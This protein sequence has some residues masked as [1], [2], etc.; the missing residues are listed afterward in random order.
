MYLNA[1][2]FL[3]SYI[4]VTY[5]ELGSQDAATILAMQSLAFLIFSPIIGDSMAV[6]GRKNTLI[7]SMVM[8]VVSTLI[9][10]VAS[11]STSASVFYWGSIVAK[12]SQGIASSSCSTSC[13]AIICSRFPERKALYLGWATLVAGVAMSIGPI[14]G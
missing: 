5:P 1:T 11:F 13:F 14:I 6:V 2:I 4:K 9:F 7:F 10:A 12:F 8:F 3:P